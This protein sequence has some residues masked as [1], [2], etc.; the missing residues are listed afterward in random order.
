MAHSEKTA[1]QIITEKHVEALHRG[2]HVWP[3]LL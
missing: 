1:E 2:F 3:E